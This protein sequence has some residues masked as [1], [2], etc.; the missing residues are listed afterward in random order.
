M[1]DSLA[2]VSWRSCCS[3]YH[4]AFAM[5]AFFSFCL[6]V[7]LFVCPFADV[8]TYLCIIC[9][10]YVVGAPMLAPALLFMR[11]PASFDEVRLECRASLLA[12]CWLL[13]LVRSMTSRRSQC[14][15]AQLR[16]LLA[17]RKRLCCVCHQL[18]RCFWFGNQQ[19]CAAGR[20]V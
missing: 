11:I 8:H 19:H 20:A 13:L 6:H 2:I 3:N 7:R 9:G 16:S 10:V 1:T 17:W 5:S 14:E 4:F 12:N 18:R 15:Q